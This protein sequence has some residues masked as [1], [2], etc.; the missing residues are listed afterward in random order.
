MSMASGR[1]PGAAL[2][3]AIDL[4]DLY[5]MRMIPVVD[6]E[7]RPIGVVSES[8]IEKALLAPFN[9]SSADASLKAAG[10]EERAHLAVQR[11]RDMRI[12]EIMTDP[13]VTID[14]HDDILDA[15]SKLRS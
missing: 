2:P 15:A 7:N 1:A 12:R 11:A 5:Q 10:P 14:E 6:E 3:D 4:M 9:S 8:D 13:P